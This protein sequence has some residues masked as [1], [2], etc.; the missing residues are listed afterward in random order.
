DGGEGLV[1]PALDGLGQLG[2]QLL[3]LLQAR[4]EVFALRDELGETLLL[5]L[6][7]LLGERID[8]PESLAA[9]LEPLDLLRQL[10]AVVAFRRLGSGLFEPAPGSGGLRLEPRPLHLDGRAPLAG[11][12]CEPPRLGLLPAE[13]PQLGRELAGPRRTRVDARLQRRLEARGQL[14][15]PGERSGKP[16]G[17]DGKRFDRER[18]RLR[19]RQ[20]F[21]GA[22]LELLGLARERPPARLELE[23]NG[24][25]RLPREPQLAP[26]GVVAVAVAGDEDAAAGPR[27]IARLREPDVRQ[28]LGDPLAARPCVN[29]ARQR[30]RSD[31]RRP[32]RTLLCPRR[33]EHGEIAEPALPRPLDERQRGRRIGGDDRGGTPRERGRDGALVACFDLEQRE[34]EPLPLLRECPCR[35]RKALPLRERVLQC[36]QALPGQTR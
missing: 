19:P 16:L 32:A 11:F 8:L 2:P 29:P 31:E 14:G 35:R 17:P 27:E 30:L 33:Q 24:L 36:R 21:L 1:E 28:E 3:E 15:R 4:L 10:V 5:A 34:R 7:L 25:G 20:G 22:P 23:Q 9:P 13:P 12:P 18:S 6:V 26:V